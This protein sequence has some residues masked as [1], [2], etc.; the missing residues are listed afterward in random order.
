MTKHPALIALFTPAKEGGY[1]IEFPHLQGCVSEGDTF[2]EA[3]DNAREALALWLEAAEPDVR[4][5]AE[6]TSKSLAPA[7]PVVV[8]IPMD[9]HI[10]IFDLY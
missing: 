3:V 8:R 2:E 4:L 9:P 10:N 6:A 1:K 5:A 7:N